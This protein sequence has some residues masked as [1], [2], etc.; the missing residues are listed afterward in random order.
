[1]IQFVLHDA[2]DTVAVVVAEGVTAGTPMTG[3]A[4]GGS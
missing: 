2:R 4:I 1:M 3:S